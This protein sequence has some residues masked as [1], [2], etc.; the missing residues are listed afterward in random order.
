MVPMIILNTYDDNDY[1][2]ETLKFI[3]QCYNKKKK[4]ERARAKKKLSSAWEIYRSKL[5]NK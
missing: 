2:S 4:K 3:V 5:Y 1:G